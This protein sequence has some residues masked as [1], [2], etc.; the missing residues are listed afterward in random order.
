LGKPNPLGNKWCD[1]CRWNSQTSFAQAKAGVFGRDSDIT[2]TSQP[3]ST[4]YRCTLYQ[5]NYHLWLLVEFDHQIPEASIAPGHVV[6]IWFP[7]LQLSLEALYVAAGAE[8]TASTAQHD[9]TDTAVISDRIQH[10][11]QLIDHFPGERIACFGSVKPD[12][13]NAAFVFQY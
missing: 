2:H 9:R 4:A 3:Q 7:S 8:K 6:M 5:N 12:F 11:L 13:K 1:L 10:L